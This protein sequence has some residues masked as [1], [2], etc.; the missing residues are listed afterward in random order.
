M[1]MLA[2][3]FLIIAVISVIK[4]TPEINEIVRRAAEED[5]K[6]SRDCTHD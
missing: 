5:E 6:N 2:V 3:I 1:T 4:V